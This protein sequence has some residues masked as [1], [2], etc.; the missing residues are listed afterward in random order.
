VAARLIA[1]V[2]TLAAAGTLGQDR[3]SP[4]QVEEATVAEVTA[5]FDRGTLTCAQLTTLYLRRIAAYEDGG[6]RL[7]SITT[8]NPEAMEAATRLDAERRAKGARGPLHCIPVVLKDNIDT[9]DMPTSNGSV[10]LKGSI[11][12]RDAH[13]VTALRE[14]GALILG[15]AAMGEF[16]GGSYNT[17]DGQ[18][19]N[20]YNLKRNTGGSSSGSAAAVAANF[21]MLAVGTDTSTS[22]R[23]PSAFNGIVG[24]RPTTGLVSRAG[25][26]PKNLEFDTAGPMART[27]TDL[28]LLLN[29]IAGPDPADPLSLQTY[30]AAPT[31]IRTSRGDGRGAYADFTPFLK[32]GALKGARLGVVRDFFG[33]DP[34]I[35]RLAD[36]AL[37][38]MRKLGATMV[39]VKLD[40]AL[41]DFYVTNG[42]PNIRT[43]ADHRFRADWEAYLSTLGPEVPKT[44]A[45]FVRIYE[46]D[47]S[48]SPRPVAGSVLDLLK[49]SLTT[50]ADDAVYKNLVQ[51]VLPEATRLK[52]AIFES[53]DVDALVFPYQTTFALPI[54]NPVSKVDDPSF[55]PTVR[56]DPS[57][58][59]GYSSIGFPGLVVPMGFGPSGLP[60]AISF[61]GRPYDEGKLIAFAY[62]YEQ[63]T[64]KR[65]PSPLVPPLPF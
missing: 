44:V 43:P 20:P 30:Q 2:C 25:I 21:A 13:I 11:P 14:A 36:T 16:A 59:A 65:R 35:D 32:P 54:S 42:G 29:V 57:I 50:S 26:A 12:R 28:T 1:I 10:I 9:A 7:N 56:P 17:I 27:V 31:S 41:L 48:R 18:T 45:E 60:M 34:A 4:F 61:M 40:P 5:A 64:R 63:A 15:K 51:K 47:V 55:V 24:L 19:T 53:H 49:R 52:L 22:V 39:E 6:P 33:G 37:A 58:F 38:D 23:G 62:D 46:A 8:I 3:P